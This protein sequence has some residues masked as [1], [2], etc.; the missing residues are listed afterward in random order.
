M[1][2]YSALLLLFLFSASAFSQVKMPT[3]SPVKIPFSESRQ[4][5]VVTAKKWD[6]TTGTAALFERANAKADWKRVGEKF[7][8]LLGRSGMAWAQDSA[9]EKAA[10]F[11]K[12]GDGKSPAGLF[13]ITFAF[14]TSSKPEQLAFPYIKVVRDTEC[15]DDPGSSHYNKIVERMKVGNFDWKSSEKMLEVGEEYGLGAF[16]AYN[17]YPVVAG[18]GSCIFLHVWKDAVTPTSGC[19]A[20][21]R[22]NVER[23]VSWLE[24]D[25]NPYLVQLPEAEFKRYRKSWNLPKL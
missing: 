21:E 13:P 2:T 6:S 11:K 4:A 1:K 16:V 17:S 5:V 9:P 25:K 24:N 19:T 18:N 23:V 10:E 12:E 14:G 20:M 8:V 15:V 22:R 3:P 7:P